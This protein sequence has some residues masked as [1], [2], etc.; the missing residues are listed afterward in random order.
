MTVFLG[1]LCS[2]IMEVNPPFLFDVEHGV[3]LAAMQRFQDSPRSE[4]GNLMVYLKLLWEPGVSSRGTTGMFFKHSCFLSKVR[5]PVQFPGTP[6]D[7]PRVVEG[8]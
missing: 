2:S 4:C 6:R 8:Q 1:T 7:S 3:A 5:T